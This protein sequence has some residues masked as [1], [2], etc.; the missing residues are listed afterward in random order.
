MKCDTCGKEIPFTNKAECHTFAGWGFLICFCPLHCP[1][2]MDGSNCEQDH[3]EEN[4]HS[5][6]KPEDHS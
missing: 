2:T 1:K 3:P 5:E 4:Q 6:P